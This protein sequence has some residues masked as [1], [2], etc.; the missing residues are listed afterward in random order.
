MVVV[1]WIAGLP[2]FWKWRPALR[3][4]A[5]PLVDLDKIMSVSSVELLRMAIVRI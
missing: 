5:I 3:A 2:S 1:S 4:P